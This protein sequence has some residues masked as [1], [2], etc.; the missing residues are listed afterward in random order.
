[1]LTGMGGVKF[2]APK[3]NYKGLLEH[4]VIQHTIR[5]HLLSIRVYL[6]GTSLGHEETAGVVFGEVEETFPF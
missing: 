6:L 4:P 1:M 2:S 5:G 3:S